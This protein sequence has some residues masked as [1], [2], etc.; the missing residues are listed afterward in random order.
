MPLFIEI[1]GKR[2]H[3]NLNNYRN[4]HYQVNNK[5]KKLYQ[6]KAHNELQGYLNARYKSISIHFHMIRGDKRKCDRS[7]VLS[8]HEKFF[9]DALVSY[10][11]IPDDNDSHI[12][13]TTYTT[14][15]IDRLNPRV[16]ITITV[17]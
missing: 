9:C 17:N 12:T 3:L 13:R 14:G 15:K 8:I 11:V 2:R 6:Q 7:N 4:W 1:S 10:G 5:I 16:E